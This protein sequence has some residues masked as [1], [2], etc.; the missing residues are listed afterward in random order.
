MWFSQ[1]LNNLYI[2][3]KFSYESKKVPE[4]T[5]CL[6]S[7]MHMGHTITMPI[8]GGIEN[9]N[10]FFLSKLKVVNFEV[11]LIINLMI[12]NFIMLAILITFLFE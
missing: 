2:F 11:L 8:F 3:V 1:I 6:I 5:T 10:I 7:F 4:E 12:E 9:V